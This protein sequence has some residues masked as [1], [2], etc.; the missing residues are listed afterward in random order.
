[1]RDR[2]GQKTG[3][4]GQAHHPQQPLEDK[5]QRH[6]CAAD[7]QH[8]PRALSPRVGAAPWAVASTAAN[9]SA[10]T[11]VGAYTTRAGGARVSSSPGNAADQGQRR[12]GI[13]ARQRRKGQ[14]PQPTA[15]GTV[16]AAADQAAAMPEDGGRQV[17]R[18]ATRP[19]RPGRWRRKRREKAPGHRKNLRVRRR[20]QSVRAAK[21]SQDFRL[22]CCSPV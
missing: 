22:P 19:V 20:G 21:V 6:G 17:G 4:R 16:T 13:V 5:G 14:Q 7:G 10:T 12:Q 9:S 8:L 18:L 11:V 2:N 1:M 15:C 3:H